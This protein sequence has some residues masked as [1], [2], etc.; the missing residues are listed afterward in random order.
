M[1]DLTLFSSVLEDR[2]T[3]FAQRYNQSLLEDIDLSVRMW[4]TQS[5]TWTRTTYCLRILSAV[6]LPIPPPGQGEGSPHKMQGLSITQEETAK[7]PETCD[8]VPW[9]CSSSDTSLI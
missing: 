4:D 9:R 1:K 6:R 5:E 2:L 3:I 7:T 8:E